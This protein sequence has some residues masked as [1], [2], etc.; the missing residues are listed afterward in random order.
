VE[1]PDIAGA[2]P[3]AEEG[4]SGLVGILPV[5][6]RNLGPAQANLAILAGR[7]A[8]A[9]IVP[10]L[11]LDMGEGPAGRADLLDLAAG[12]HQ[13]VA[14][15]AFGEPIAVD[16]ARVLEKAGEGADARF[17]GLLAATDRP[18]QAC[19]IV[20]IAAGAGEQGAGHDRREPGRGEL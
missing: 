16:V 12:L 10:D 8:V 19:N 1:V 3:V 7:K 11:D 6:T 2:E 15:A 13:R 9:A 18:A 20:P 4:R 17:R 5:A 14:A